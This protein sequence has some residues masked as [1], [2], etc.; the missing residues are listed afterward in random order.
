MKLEVGKYY[1]VTIY[2]SDVHNNRMIVYI[3]YKLGNKFMIKCIKDYE[4]DTKMDCDEY[5]IDS[6]MIT[7][8]KLLNNKELLACTL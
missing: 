1:D 6:D 5:Y 2:F 7:K 8:Y 4:Y 3:I